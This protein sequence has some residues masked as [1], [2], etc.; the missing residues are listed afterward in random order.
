MNKKHRIFICVLALPLVPVS[1]AGRCVAQTA[2]AATKT[3]IARVQATDPKIH[4]VIAL[5]PTALD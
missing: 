4:A 2:E 1:T 5:D 3:A